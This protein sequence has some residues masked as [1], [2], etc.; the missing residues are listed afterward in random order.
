MLVIVLGVSEEMSCLQSSPRD[1]ANSLVPVDQLEG[2]SEGQSRIGWGRTACD[3]LT[4]P[5]QFLFCFV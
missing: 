3:S 5:Q 4:P 1:Q 2:S